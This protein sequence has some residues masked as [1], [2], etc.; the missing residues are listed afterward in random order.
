VHAPSSQPGDRRLPVYAFDTVLHEKAVSPRSEQA[1]LIRTPFC[2]AFLKLRQR[3]GL[4]GSSTTEGSA[5][6]QRRVCK[7][8]MFCKMR[9]ARTAGVIPHAAASAT[10]RMLP[11][12]AVSRPVCARLRHAA[13]PA[14]TRAAAAIR[15]RADMRPQAPFQQR[16][17]KEQPHI[18]ASEC[19]RRMRRKRACVRSCSSETSGR[20]PHMRLLSCVIPADVFFSLFRLCSALLRGGLSCL[21]FVK[22]MFSRSS[23][24]LPSGPC[25]TFPA[26]RAALHKR[27]LSQQTS[28]TIDYMAA[29]LPSFYL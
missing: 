10:A 6:P 4:R 26:Y 20:Q 17:P 3:T 1:R 14:A 7:G 12:H 9:P 5:C 19:V 21:S 24:Q 18:A 16:R 27:Y 2:D 15:R 22:E 28:L 8:D 29:F 25:C 23:S 13:R 11:R